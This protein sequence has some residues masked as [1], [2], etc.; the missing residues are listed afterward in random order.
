M[1]NHVCPHIWKRSRP[2]RLYH[3]K[4]YRLK[5]GPHYANSDRTERPGRVTVSAPLISVQGIRMRACTRSSSNA[6]FH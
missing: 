1:G 3:A 2:I 5:V 6:V 4:Q